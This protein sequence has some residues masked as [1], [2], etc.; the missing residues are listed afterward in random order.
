[1]KA[2]PVASAPG[3][4]ESW[5]STVL[6]ADN[7]IPFR[8]WSANLDEMVSTAYEFNPDWAALNA[9]L[10]ALDGQEHVAA[11]GQYPRLGLKGG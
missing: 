7:A 6:P 5:R 9:G 8:A 11:S 10:Q 1:M 3:I 2:S 4:G